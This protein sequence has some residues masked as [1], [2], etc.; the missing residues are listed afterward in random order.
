M[1]T[2]QR[3]RESVSALP[4]PEHVERMMSEGWR[5]AGV[6]WEREVPAA[7]PQ[8]GGQLELDVPFGLRVA[9][10]CVH[11]E[12]NPAERQVLVLALDLVIDEDLRL[13]QV[14]EELN[15]RG[16]R[17]RA[18]EPWT[19]VSVFNLLPRLIEVGPHIFSSAEWEQR[20]RA[21][22]RMTPA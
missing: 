20:R 13:T 18:G 21:L 1:T 14:A 16:F 12:E 11:L 6:E 22:N 9:G 15:R 5:L 10:D 8:V 4:G 3:I 19:P 17:T 7:M 2:L